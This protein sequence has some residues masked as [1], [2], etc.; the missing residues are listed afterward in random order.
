MGSQMKSR[1][2]GLL[3]LWHS[4]IGI[5]LGSAMLVLGLLF[6]V[7][8]RVDASVPI[9]WALAGATVVSAVG[10][11]VDMVFATATMVHK[12]GDARADDWQDPHPG[13]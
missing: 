6:I 11:L 8:R 4:G 7:A 2:R 3:G 12:D 1:R 9:V 5:R 10:F 13:P